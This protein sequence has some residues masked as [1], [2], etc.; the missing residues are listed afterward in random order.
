MITNIRLRSQQLL[1]PEFNNPKDLV[2]WMGAMQAQD[3]PRVKWALGVRLKSATIRTIDEAIQ[4]GDILR[5]HVMRP[6]WHFVTAEDIRWMLKLSSQ[7]IITACNSYVKGGGMDIPESLYT[8]A[9]DQFAKLLEGNNHLTKQE[10]GDEIVRAGILPDSTLLSSLITRAEQEGIVCSGSD[11][12]GKFT[13]ALLAERAPMAKD[14]PR[15][16]ALAL[17]ARRYFCS[18]SPASQDDFVWWSGLSVTEARQAIGLIDAELIKDKFASQNFFVHEQWG[19]RFRNSDVLHFLPPYDEYLIS[20]KDRTAAMDKE[21]HPK[22]FNNFGIFYPVILHN[23]RIIGNWKK[24]VKKGGFSIETSFFGEYPKPD[25]EQIEK[26]VE[27][28]NRF[29]CG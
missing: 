8:K 14:L 1:K 23:G 19:K 16:E 28:Y 22:A 29:F 12:D 18:H 6:T 26:A 15:E 11:K 17:L 21:H 20:Y 3:Y 10:L 13:Y 25:D 24:K 27:K 2:S 7:R 4:R 5:T 9:N